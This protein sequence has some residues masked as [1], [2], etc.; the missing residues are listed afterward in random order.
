MEEKF[1]KFIRL[2]RGI[3]WLCTIVMTIVWITLLINDKNYKF[4][5]LRTFTITAWMVMIIFA[6]ASFFLKTKEIKTREH[7]YFLY[8]GWAKVVLMCDGVVVDMFKGGSY[9]PVNLEYDDGKD[10]KITVKISRFFNSYT[11]KINGKILY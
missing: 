2:S 5:M 1:K 7:V 4:V 3:V 11:V 9:A 8:L 10:E 6:I